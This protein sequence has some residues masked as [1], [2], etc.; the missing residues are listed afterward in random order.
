MFSETTAAAF[1]KR[2][3]SPQ[4]IVNTVTSRASRVFKMCKKDPAGGGAF[5]DFLA[6]AEDV[7][8]NSPDFATAQ[9]GATDATTTVGSQFLVPWCEDNTVQRIKA[10]AIAQS[11]NNDGAWTQLLKYAMDSCMRLAAFSLSLSLATQGWGEVCQITASAGSTFKCLRPEHIHRLYKGMK[12]QFSQLLNT[13][14]L[15]SAT[16]L[17]ITAIDPNANLVTLSGTL[18]SVSAVDNDFAFIAGARDNSATPGR[19]KPSGLPVWLPAQPVT[20]TT[21][22]TLYNVVRSNNTRLYGNFTDGTLLSIEQA[23]TTNAQVVSSIGNAEG[24][25]VFVVAPAVYTALSTELGSNKRY[26]SDA[27]QVGFKTII[28][29]VDGVEAKVIPDKFFD[30]QYAYCIDPNTVVYAS[31]GA[32]PQINDVDGNKVLRVADDNAVEVRVV[33]YSC[34]AVKDPMSCGTVALPAVP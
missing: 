27:G 10:K 31:I 5:Y 24:Q 11:K 34:I 33:S 18:A 14:V 15:R 4:Y 12:L 3:Y 9:S 25:R 23:L 26:N 6:V 17:T 13:T 29:D 8:G 19:N 21:I 7:G 16:I 30:T 1:L 28:V 32:L 22:S 20:D 2:K